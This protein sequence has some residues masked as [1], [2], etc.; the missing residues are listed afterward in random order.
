MRGEENTRSGEVV[1]EGDGRS[2]EAIAFL[3]MKVRSCHAAIQAASGALVTTKDDA[4]KA[5][6]Q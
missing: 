4:V 1:G 5:E 3:W 2:L 6:T